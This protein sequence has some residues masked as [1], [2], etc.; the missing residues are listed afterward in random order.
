MEYQIKKRDIGIVVLL[1]VVTLGI[2][3]KTHK[4]NNRKVSLGSIVLILSL[5]SFAISI[6]S[7]GVV[8]LLS[9]VI[10]AWATCLVQLEINFLSEEIKLTNL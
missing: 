10:G 4:I 5:I 2:Y 6:L 1:G 8:F 3:Y 9:M 7:G